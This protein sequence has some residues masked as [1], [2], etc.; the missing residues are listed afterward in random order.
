M[1]KIILLAVLLV[2]LSSTAVA[3]TKAKADL[4]NL[5]GV[6]KVDLRPTPDAAAYF[7][8]F[9]ITKIEGAAFTGKFY[10]AAIKNGRINT[11]WDTVYLAFTSED[12]SG[13][14]SHFARVVNG[15]LEGGTHSLGRNFLLLWRAEKEV[16]KT[17][18]EKTDSKTKP[19]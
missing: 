16:L 11:D 9:E 17:E 4:T 15:R 10:G 18:K 7:Q 1:K 2:G 6:W 14:Y 13:I 5:I 3:Q 19:N 12:G 8:P